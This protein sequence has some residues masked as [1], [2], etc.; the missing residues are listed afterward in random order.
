[1]CA[2]PCPA[3]GRSVPLGQA[4]PPEA[5]G[6]ALRG[7]VDAH[8]VQGAGKQKWERAWSPETGVGGAVSLFCPVT[9]LRTGNH[10]AEKMLPGELGGWEWG[11]SGS[12]PT[13]P[14]MV[15]ESESRQG[16]L[17]QKQPGVAMPG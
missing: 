4:R 1:M 13:L 14:E 12:G 15:L 9:R 6:Q 3:P 17:G 10:L 5:L 8:R 2:R 16:A 7:A 11:P